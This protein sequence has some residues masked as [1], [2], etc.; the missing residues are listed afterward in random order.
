[1]LKELKKRTCDVPGAFVEDNRF[2]ISV[3]YRH[4]LNEVNY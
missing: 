3:H 4:V 1:M 2:C